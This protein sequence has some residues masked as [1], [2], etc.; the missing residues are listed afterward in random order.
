MS[1]HHLKKAI[2]YTIYVDKEDDPFPYYNSLQK[3]RLYREQSV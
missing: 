2:L 3:Y 1:L